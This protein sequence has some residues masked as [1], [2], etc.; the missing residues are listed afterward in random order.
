MRSG[1]RASKASR[2]VWTR[3]HPL[4]SSAVVF[5]RNPPWPHPDWSARRPPKLSADSSTTHRHSCCSPCMAALSEPPQH[6]YGICSRWQPYGSPM[7]AGGS[8]SSP[9]CSPCCVQDAGTQGSWMW[10]LPRQL[11]RCKAFLRDTVERRYFSPRFHLSKHL[12]TQ[13]AISASQVVPRENKRYI[14]LM[15]GLQGRCPQLLTS[16]LPTTGSP[17]KAGLP[18][19]CMLC[20]NFPPCFRAVTAARAVMLAAYKI[21]TAGKRGNTTYNVHAK[22]PPEQLG[23]Y[24]HTHGDAVLNLL[25]V[26]SP[27]T[28]S[29]YLLLS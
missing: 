3:L 7:A 23:L 6:I 16:T 25:A 2:L 17:Y 28:P 18:Q 10:P 21:R 4:P 11:G 14:L 1:S 8:V 29:S 27:S 13:L 22:S 24:H 5:S 9:V 20:Q 26:G 19:V 15:T 12:Q